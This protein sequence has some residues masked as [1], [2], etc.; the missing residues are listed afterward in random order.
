MYKHLIYKTK[1]TILWLR[2]L[3]RDPS[4]EVEDIADSD[5]SGG[6]KSL[7]SSKTWVIVVV[8]TS[9]L[10][11]FRRRQR[12]I[13]LSMPRNAEEL[14]DSLNTRY[15]Y[16]VL[17]GFYVCLS[18]PVGLLCSSI[19]YHTPDCLKSCLGLLLSGHQ[20]LIANRYDAWPIS[21]HQILS[22]FEEKGTRD[23]SVMQQTFSKN[24]IEIKCDF[25]KFEDEPG[26][27]FNKVVETK[28]FFFSKD[29][30]TFK[31]PRQVLFGS[32]ERNKQI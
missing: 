6:V 18:L 16:L 3:I 2:I 31:P 9:C 1:T 28:L 19:W 17:L 32:K 15:Y 20:I 25:Q 27:I 23:K 5:C 7:F 29:A 8:F 14:I 13:A 4:S 11:V 12:I 26:R 24:L 30:I 22:S 21:Q 10:T